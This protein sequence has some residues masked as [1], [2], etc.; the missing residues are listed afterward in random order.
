MS[1]LITSFTNATVKLLRS[2]HEKKHREAE[3]LFLAEGMRIVTEAVDCGH[4]PKLLAFGAAVR[5]HPLLQRLILATESGGGRVIET[6][7]EV[8][9]KIA[10][11]D[12]PQMVVAAFALPDLSLARLDHHKLQLVLVLEALKDP[13]NLGTILRTG[14]AVGAS[15]IILLDHCCDP[16]ATEAVR[17]SMGALFTQQLAQA[18]FEEFLPWLRAAPAQLIGASLNTSHDYRDIS[19][20]RPC[21]LFM[22]NEQSGLPPAYEQ[23]CDALVKIPMHGKADSLNVAI[24]TAVLAYE[25]RNQ[26]RDLP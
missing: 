4:M 9:A 17:A 18:R 13:G 1:A 6:S 8:L 23:A 7:D 3:G 5:T 2:L 19:Y 21:F 26:W 15:A 16:F 12:N 20:T 25:V 11:K 22:G 24:S 10:R 14:D